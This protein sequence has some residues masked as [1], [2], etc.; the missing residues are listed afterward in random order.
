M[1]LNPLLGNNAAIVFAVALLFS[2][3]AS[4]ITSAM[5]AGTIFAGLYKE[6]YDIKDNHSRL[7]VSISLVTALIIIFLISD[8]FSGLI[9]SQM[10][11]SIQLPFTIFS[12]VYLTSSYKVMGK[13]KNSSFLKIIL[14]AI[15][16]IVTLLNLALFI[17]IFITI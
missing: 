9:F 2:G 17:N 5:A 8:P 7:G 12:Q 6:P 11:L 15:G 14:Y 1:L 3:I 13:Y 10:F 16:I 4:T